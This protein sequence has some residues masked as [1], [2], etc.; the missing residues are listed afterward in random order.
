MQR[1]LDGLAV[2]R[3][4]VLGGVGDAAV[5]RRDH[6]GV[7]PPC[8][9]RHERGDVDLDL[10]VEDRLRLRREGPPLLERPL[11]AG[12]LRRA[13]ATLEVGEGRVVGTDH[14]GAGAA[15]DRHVADGQPALHRKRLDRRPRVLEHV[16]DAAGDADLPDR[17]QHHVLRRDTEAPAAREVDAHRP[18]PRL[19]QRLRREHVLHLRA[20]DAERER[21]ER[22]VSR[23]VRVAAHDRHPRLRHTELR[24][25]DV[26]DPLAPAPGRVQGYAEGLAVRGQ[27]VELR[28]RDQVANRPR[29]GRDVVVH[30]RD[31]QVGSPH[32]S[33]RESQPLKCLRA[34]HLVHE[35]QVDEEQRRLPRALVDNVPVPDLLEER[36]HG[37][38]QLS[39]R[40]SQ[41]SC[42]RSAPPAST[43]GSRPAPAA[44]PRPAGG[45]P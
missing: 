2:G 16:A 3:V 32:C 44:A 8:H 20:A 10:A 33:S 38:R 14:P 34:R 17:A 4:G 28:L 7:R 36:R 22:A 29:L 23:G 43:P 15:L 1:P 35:M 40:R 25:H 30:G 11:P 41:G 6:P 31:R 26:H 13:R 37:S 5:D 19:Q 42:R 9:L 45:S 21:G 27:R 24:P 12:A 39:G 18:R